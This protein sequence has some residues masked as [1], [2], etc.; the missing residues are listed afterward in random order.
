MVK[1]F[2]TTNASEAGGVDFSP[3]PEGTYEMIV[4]EVEIKTFN[5]G[6][7]GL[8]V[9]YTIRDDVDQAGKKRIVFDNLV[10]TERAMFKFNQVAKALPELDGKNFTSED[11]LLK[12]FARS[13]KGKAIRVTIGHDNTRDSFIEVVKGLDQSSL[14]TSGSGANPF[15]GDG[16][17]IDISDEDLPF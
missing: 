14:G 1:S 5:S 3:I 6:N 2:F 15:A 7:K 11:Q 16:N 12:E 17:A 8:S 13:M 10:C 9:R 4:S